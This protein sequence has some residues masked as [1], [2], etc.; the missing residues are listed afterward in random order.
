[1]AEDRSPKVVHGVHFIWVGNYDGAQWKER[2]MCISHPRSVFVFEPS[3]GEEEWRVALFKV[4]DF[5][6]F[7]MFSRLEEEE[8]FGTKRIAWE[9]A[10]EWARRPVG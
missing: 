9:K 8:Y 1:M 7:P 10:V 2:W 4:N 6:S 3:D 5:P